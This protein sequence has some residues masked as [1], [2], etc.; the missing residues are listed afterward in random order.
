MT[1]SP[2]CPRL[3]T[4]E[5]AES[6]CR[7]R[8]IN[9]SRCSSR[10][11][12]RSVTPGRRFEQDQ[13]RARPEL[14]KPLFTLKSTP[15]DPEVI[16]RLCRPR[17]VSRPRDSTEEIEFKRA[18]IA[19]ARLSEKIEHNRHY[20]RKVLDNPIGVKPAP[21]R[22]ITKDFKEMVFA[23]EER[24]RVRSRSLSVKRSA[25]TPDRASR[26]SP[27]ADKL[28]A[29][30]NTESA[31]KAVAVVNTPVRALLQGK[32]A[33]E[34]LCL[35]AATSRQQVTTR[36]SKLR[37]RSPWVPPE[38]ANAPHDVDRDLEEEVELEA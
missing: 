11:A 38:R 30:R 18:Q 34:V 35:R 3:M 15:V 19:Q 12:S 1:C 17:S 37:V 31:A 10:M 25:D 8:S 36:G 29:R 13:R 26:L 21:A 22:M 9:L 16:E 23:T 7:S 2:K 32:S 14:K 6:R 24:A 20:M 33:A 5:R 4:A 27:R 28:A